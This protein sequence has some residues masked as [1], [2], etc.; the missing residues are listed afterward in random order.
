LGAAITHLGFSQEEI[1]EA[2]KAILLP[3]AKPL[4]KQI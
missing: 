1:E 3:K 2:I 4:L